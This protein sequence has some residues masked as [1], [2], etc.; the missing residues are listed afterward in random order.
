MNTTEVIRN[1]VMELCNKKKWSY[2]TLANLS[3][4]PASVLKDLILGKSVI[5]TMTT[6]KMLCDSF[7]ITLGEFFNTLEFDDLSKETEQKT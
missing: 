2:H 4:V 3:E 7:E 1:R 5:L 6:V